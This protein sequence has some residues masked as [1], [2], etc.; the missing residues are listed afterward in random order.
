M[1]DCSDESFLDIDT[2]FHLLSE[3]YRRYALYY[4]M[5]QDRPIP[6]E[7]LVE[8]VVLWDQTLPLG[9]FYERHEIRRELTDVHIPE[10]QEHGVIEYDV[11]T[12]IAEANEG[13]P[14]LTSVLQHAEQTNR[15]SK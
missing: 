15:S 1:T 4:V 7:E 5:G 3:R 13:F 11:Q 8:Q 9:P 14:I 2:I 12:Q 6:L 10:L